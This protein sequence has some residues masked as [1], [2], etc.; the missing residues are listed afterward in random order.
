MR[1]AK[2]VFTGAGIYGILTV[3]PLYFLEGYIS[4][5]TGPVTYPEYFYGFIGV[6]VAFQIVFLIIGRDPVRLRPIM[7]ACMVEKI[8]FGAAIFPL[9]AAHRVQSGVVIFASIDLILCALFIASWFKTAA[10][11]TTT[12]K[13]QLPA[14][15]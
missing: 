1:F 8:S 6:T 7:P 5:A 2:W 9:Y 12:A 15:A 13:E 4:Q 3:A 11:A 10:T 14:T